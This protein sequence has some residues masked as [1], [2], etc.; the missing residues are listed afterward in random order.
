[1]EQARRLALLGGQG[2]Y[3]VTKDLLLEAGRWKEEYPKFLAE[4]KAARSE[5]EYI[6]ILDQK[7]EKALLMERVRLY[8][9]WVFRYGGALFSEYS[10]EICA[11]CAERICKDAENAGDRK[12]YQRACKLIQMLAE[13]GGTEEVTRLIAELRQ[14]YPR[15]RAMQDELVQVERKISRKA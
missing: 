9:E 11:L 4:L 2:F 8:P 6:K 12:A 3:Q 13:F 5:Y 7:G 1:M 10:G 15:R 14:G